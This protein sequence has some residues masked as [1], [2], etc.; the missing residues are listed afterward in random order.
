[1]FDA[2]R[3]FLSRILASLVAACCTWLTVKFKIEIDGTTQTALSDALSVFILTSSYAVSHRFLDKLWNPADSASSHLAVEGKTEVRAMKVA[4]HTEERAA[5]F[6]AADSM[7]EP[8]PGGP[9]GV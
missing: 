3:P 5:R 2:L 6:G 4:E 7:Q 1:M 9:D 8:P